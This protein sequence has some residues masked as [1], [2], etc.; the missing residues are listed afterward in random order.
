MLTINLFFRGAGFGGFFKG[1]LN[2]VKPVISSPITKEIAKEVFNTG[3]K[4]GADV[5]SGQ[6]PFKESMKSNMSNIK[7]NLNVVKSKVAKTILDSMNQRN[8]IDEDLE[9][10]DSESIGLGQDEFVKFGVKNPRKRKNISFKPSSRKKKTK[11]VE[12]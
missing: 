9:S 1:L 3:L 10:E 8:V 4:I 5:I 2:Y 12:L 6:K 7:K 11:I